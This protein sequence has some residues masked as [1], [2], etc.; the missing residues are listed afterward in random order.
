[1]VSGI[2]PLGEGLEE[3]GFDFLP[4]T[5]LESL[6]EFPSFMRFRAC[7][8]DSLCQVAARE[9]E[10]SWG[11]ILSPFLRR[12]PITTEADGFHRL[13]VGVLLQVLED[14]EEASVSSKRRAK[15]WGFLSLALPE[16]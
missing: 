2:L 11:M 7:S 4:G 6:P 9:D 12:S 5:L 3:Q 16:S 14:L 8:L 15:S 10:M 13:K 1:L